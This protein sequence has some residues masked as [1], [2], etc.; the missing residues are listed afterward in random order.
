MMHHDASSYSFRGSLVTSWGLHVEKKPQ[1]NHGY[2]RRRWRRAGSVVYPQSWY[3]SSSSG[4]LPPT[5][6]CRI[7]IKSLRSQ[8]TYACS[9]NEVMCLG[10]SIPRKDQHPWTTSGDP[11]CDEYRTPSQN[12]CPPNP[13]IHRQIERSACCWSV[14]IPF[15]SS[16]AISSST[17]SHFVFP[18][19]WFG[20][21]E[22]LAS[23][24]TP[25]GCVPCSLL[26]LS[27]NKFH[28]PSKHRRNLG[29]DQNLF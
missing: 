15:L 29:M 28:E 7:V 6:T 13:A 1:L 19:I 27:A 21:Q 9:T 4:H 22:M 26:H 18:T 5:K 10:G 11:T 12:G 25:L 14:G 24:L 16:P 23:Q 17:S 2:G 8:N 20:L 3:F